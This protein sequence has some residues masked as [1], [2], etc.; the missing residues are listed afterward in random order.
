MSEKFVEFCNSAIHF[1][2]RAKGMFEEKVLC[3]HL[4]EISEGTLGARSR[5]AHVLF[6]CNFGRNEASKCLEVSRVTELFILNN[7]EHLSHF[8]MRNTDTNSLL[9]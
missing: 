2:E 5:L 9:T 3:K 6:H 4:H 1:C 7:F 8:I